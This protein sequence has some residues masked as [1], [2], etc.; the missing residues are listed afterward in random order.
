M[1]LQTRRLDGVAAAAS[2]R[3]EVAV[4]VARMAEAGAPA[5]C[6]AAVLVGD[7]RASAVYVRTKIKACL[8]AGIVP[9]EHRV[10]AK[11]QESDLVA[12]I[13][14]L[15]EDDTVDG[16]LMQ[17]PLPRGIHAR[18]V[19]DAIDPTK[20]VDG[21]HP[22][23]VGRLWS[24]E[25]GFVPCTP[26]GVMCLLEKEKI[27]LQGCE[28]VV[29]GRSDIVGKPM[30][31]LLIKASATVTVCHSRTRDLPRIAARADLLVAAIGRPGFVTAEFIKP[32]ATVID[33]GINAVSS[34]KAARDLFG[35]DARRLEDI[36]QKGYTLAGDVHPGQADGRAGA[37]SPVPG[38]V[39]PL[40]VALLL[41]NTLEAARRRRAGKGWEGS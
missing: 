40:T 35:E 39:G 37:L 10:D 11:V 32:G 15:G 16:I 29:I 13:R 19:I 4:S 27:E 14:R 34:E 9:R 33:V 20:D 41:S 26:L 36:R 12:L 1:T 7:D 3:A 38:G 22:V 6:L 28:A 21:F 31:A 17:M 18:A 2:V 30:A 24:G 5:P 25:D 23:N 8:E